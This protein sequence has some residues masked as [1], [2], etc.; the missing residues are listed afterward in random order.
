[1]AEARRSGLVGEAIKQAKQARKMTLSYLQGLTPE[2]LL[3]RA[4]AD[5][6]PILWLVWHLGEVE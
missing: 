3:W 6:N 5:A 4:G 1:M 2:Q